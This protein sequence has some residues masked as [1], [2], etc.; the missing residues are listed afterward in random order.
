MRAPSALLRLPTLAALCAA[1]VVGVAPAWAAPE[2]S[3]AIARF[4]GE[5][6]LVAAAEPGDPSLVQQVRDRASDWAATISPRSPRKRAMASPPSG[7]AR[8]GAP[9]SASTAH[10]AART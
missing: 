10:S 1:L 3:D 2:G 5:R 7:A 6:G 8:A 4:L 9:L